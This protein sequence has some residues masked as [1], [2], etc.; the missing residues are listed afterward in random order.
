[1]A[2][3]SNTTFF[4]NVCQLVSTMASPKHPQSLMG[5]A[6]ASHNVTAVMMSINSKATF[7]IR[8]R[9]M[10]NSRQMPTPNSTA[11]SNTDAHSV[12]KSGTSCCMCSASR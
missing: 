4:Q 1:M 5:L 8:R 9:R 12:M 6:K 10:A 11:D 7:D 2:Q 3:A